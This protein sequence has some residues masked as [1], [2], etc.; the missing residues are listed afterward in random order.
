[1]EVES[2]R[3]NPVAVIENP[4]CRGDSPPNCCT[5][6]GEKSPKK[7]LAVALVAKQ[8]PAEVQQDSVEG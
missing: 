7:L 8:L 1:M 3:N 5:R 4:I 2:G 6:R